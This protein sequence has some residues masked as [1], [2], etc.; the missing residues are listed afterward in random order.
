[1]PTNLDPQLEKAI[2]EFTQKK[3]EAEKKR[4]EL[5]NK[6]AQGGVKGLA[7]KNEIEQLDVADKTE[8]NKVEITLNA[9]KKK[10]Q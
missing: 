2:E 3:R 1:L 5:E 7:A 6:A 9:A 8:L 4:V 10:D